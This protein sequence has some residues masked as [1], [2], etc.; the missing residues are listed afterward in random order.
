MKGDQERCRDAGMD[1]YLAKP[2]RPDDLNALLDGFPGSLTGAPGSDPAVE[3]EPACQ[4]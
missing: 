2:I 4:A 1:G 3:P